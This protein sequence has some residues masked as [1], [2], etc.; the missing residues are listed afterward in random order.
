MI[1]QLSTPFTAHT[2]YPMLMIFHVFIKKKI[3]GDVCSGPGRCVLGMERTSPRRHPQEAWSVIGESDVWGNEGSVA[4]I[5]LDEG[6][7][8]ALCCRCKEK[9]TQFGGRSH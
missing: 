1:S 3:S 8:V 2:I 5:R 6:I 9:E 4:R 7:S